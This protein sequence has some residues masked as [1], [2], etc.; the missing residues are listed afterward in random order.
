M[1]RT[2]AIAAVTI[3]AF[4]CSLLPQRDA[5]EN[6][7]ET[8]P[9]YGKYLNTGTALDT[10]IQQRLD[11]L[12]ADPNSA[13]LHNELGALLVQKGFPKDAIVEFERSVDADRKFYPAW[14]NLGMLHAAQGHA[15]GARRALAKTVDL[16]PGHPH[17][18]FQLGLI[19]EKSGDNERAVELYAKAFRHNPAM[20]DVRYN[21][22]ILDSRLVH[23]AML[24]L[25]PTEQARRAIQFHGAPAGY[26]SDPATDA[27]M[28]AESA[29]TQAPSTAPAKKQ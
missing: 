17:A 11:A 4:G 26:R 14:Y 10:Q 3:A 27:A 22:H 24:K 6:P 9:F 8:A 13:P 20:M 1:I 28:A 29:K 16:K 21:P 19:E 15:H 23:L 2:L 7:Y 18:L 5:S 25:Y 12:R